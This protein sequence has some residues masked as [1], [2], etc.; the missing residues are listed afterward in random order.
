MIF[1][2][3]LAS[4]SKA[5]FLL[6]L[7]LYGGW[8]EEQLNQMTLDEKIGQLFVAPACP[9]RGSDHWADWQKLLK[10][11]HVGN[12]LVKQS[13]PLA[14]IEFLNRLQDESKLPMLVAADA[15]WGLAM[16]MEDTICYP[17][18]MTLG[19]IENLDLIEKVGFEIGRQAKLVG[20]HIN[21]AP[22]AD[23]N[24]N[25]ENPVIGRR[26]FG[27]DPKRVADHVAA[28]VKGLEASGTSGCLKH[29]P[30]HGDTDVDSHWD[31][32]IIN[33]SLERL[34][35]VEWPPF[36]A[37]ISAGASFLMSAHL[38]MPEIDPIYPTSLS[39]YCLDLAREELNF[40]GLILS[41]ALN[42]G[43]LTHRYTPQEIA[44]LARQAG[45]DLLL[46]GAHEKPYVD[47][48]M[49]E[50]IP[51]AFIALK[52]AYLNGDLS[53]EELDLSVLKIL[54]KKE[55]IQTSLDVQNVF[56][57]LNSPE[58][59]S[60]K[61]ELYQNA[62]TQIGDSFEPIQDGIYMSFGSGD[63]LS[64][65]F[66]C[67][68]KIIIA[69]HDEAS[70]TPETLMQIETYKDEAILCLFASPYNLD[71]F[72]GFKTIL[73]AYENDPDAQMSLL[74]VLK[75]KEPARGSLPVSFTQ[76]LR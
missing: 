2:G 27:E 17:K 74:E 52:L 47:Q 66:G 39:K 43:A 57:Q 14:Q 36:K 53:L 1:P 22:V 51:G 28:F 42:M 18:N 45:C 70:I 72:E 56:V 75:G 60:L 21:L 44:L 25:P 54:R 37:G 19:A 13:D 26:S 68:G 48:I 3:S 15:E 69:I 8:A 49:R 30:G 23:V 71:Y 38:Y 16:R 73:I 67:E 7:L 5:A 34:E 12:I 50:N 46:Y 76:E 4:F 24:S 59:L 61:K 33:H 65:E 64:G 32:P 41:D 40:Q 55:S 35:V 29:F 11:Y 20:V 9:K 31:L 58:A 6:P 62:I 10:D 63:I